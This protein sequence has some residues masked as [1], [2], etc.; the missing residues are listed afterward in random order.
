MFMARHEIAGSATEPGDPVEDRSAMSRRGV[1]KG[2]AGAGLVA[3]GAGAAVV[4]GGGPAGATSLQDGAG[5]ESVVAHVRDVRTGAVD[6]F[7]GT[8]QVTIHDREL[9]VRL[10]N[11]AN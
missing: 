10:A 5:T 1:L 2:A 7:V 11:A 6:V 4:V 3:A 8:R 9:A